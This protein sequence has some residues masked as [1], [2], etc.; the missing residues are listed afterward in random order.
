MNNSA[1][2]PLFLRVSTVEALINC[3]TK[4]IFDC[5]W[6]PGE[7]IT[8]STLTE[9][10]GVSRHSVREALTILVKQGLLK[11]E[12]NKGVSIPKFSTDDIKDLYITRALFEVEA[13]RFLTKEGEVNDQIYEALEGFKSQKQNDPWSNVIE[14]DVKFHKTIVDS[15][16]SPRISNLFSSLLTEF[17]LIN[18][19]PRKY[20]P[21]KEVYEKHKLLVD[22][23]KSKDVEKATAIA[24][25]HLMESAN[26][27]I[28]EFI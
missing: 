11:K 15:M 3:I 17:R 9:K 16:G 14:M 6:E 4:E 10:Y 20:K 13:V 7:Q 1:Q 12:I 21:I 24:R 26:F 22:T 25:A 23:I 18:R 8:E 19:Q 2:E 27:H 5:K 28:S